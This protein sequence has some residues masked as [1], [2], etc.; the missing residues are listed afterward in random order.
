MIGDNFR[1]LGLHDLNKKHIGIG[2]PDDDVINGTDGND[3]IFALRGNDEIYAAAGND[4]VFGNRGNDLIDGGTGNDSL[5]GNKGNDGLAGRDGKDFLVGDGGRDFMVGGPGDDTLDGGRDSDTFVFRVGMNK[6]RVLHFGSEDRLDLRDFGLA[7]PQDVLNAFHQV[8]HDAV[9]D[10]GNGDKVIL[11]HYSVAKLTGAQLITSDLQ[12]GPSSSQTPYIVDLDPHI[13]FTSVLTTGDSPSGSTYQMVG[14]PDG[15]G[16]FD[17][18]DGTFTLLMNHE[19]GVTSG[20]VHAHGAAGA[21]V[22]AWTI[23]KTS[24]KVIEGH[25]LIQHVHL[26]DTATNSFYDPVADGNPA[27]TPAVFSRFCSADLAD[28]NAFYNPETGLGY[29]GGRIYLN[30]EEDG[31]PF[32]APGRA[33][34]HFVSGPQEGN[35][36][37]LPWLG[38]LAHENVV[39]SPYTGDATVVATMDDTSPLGQVYFYVG[40]K[41]KTGSD[42]DKAGLTGGDFF[43]V[44]VDEM[45][46]ETTAA[47][48]LGGDDQSAFSLYNFH[49]VAN[50]SGADLETQGVN[51]VTD[52]LRPED[53]AWDTTDPDRFYFVTTDAFN[54]PSR[55]WALDFTDASHPELG[56]T[57]KLLLNGTEGQNMLDNLTVNKQGHVIMQEDIG[58][59][60]PLGKIW[61]YDPVTDKL[62]LL[63]QHDPDRFDPNNVG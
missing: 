16:A 2:T 28:P 7:S 60:V 13:S 53:G 19:L 25:D 10:L 44:K 5:F 22:S 34:A 46:T 39:A 50:L 61:D 32:G 48:P 55:L 4:T 12:Q 18:G 56:G 57:I 35:T 20:A 51:N 17:N 31:P 42:L 21:F 6:D 3:T 41:Q 36:Y 27:T 26:Y 63:A 15:L 43:G 11:D 40:H 9:L 38:K 52:F 24:L 59:N 49:N 54:Q 30:G 1:F 23:D 29:N 37:E 14:I 8:G 62:T 33:F 45:L 47:N 58:N